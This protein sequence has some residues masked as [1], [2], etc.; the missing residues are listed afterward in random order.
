[1]PW[2]YAPDKLATSPKDQVRAEI[3]DTDPNDP[4]LLDE[5]ITYALTTERNMWA[6]AARCAEMIARKMLRKADVRLGRAMM[7]TYTKAAEQYFMMAKALRC[8]AMGTT[9]P[10]IGGMNINDQ[11]NYA[12]NTDIIQPVFT[13]TMMENPRVG[14]YTTDSDFPTVGSQ[15]V[16]DL[17]LSDIDQ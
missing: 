14:G 3:Q 12:E 2:T 6:A 8:K 4:Q 16:G 17:D 13:M 1:M 15:E 5:E 11:V 10:W 7:V 9:P